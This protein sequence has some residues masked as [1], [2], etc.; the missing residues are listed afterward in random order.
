MQ[1]K[2]IILGATGQLGARIVGLLASAQPRIPI[3]GVSRQ[4]SAALQVEHRSADVHSAP[5]PGLIGPGDVVIDA[6]GPH[7]HDPRAWVSATL[8]ANAHWLDLSDNPEFIARVQEVS[9]AKRFATSAIPGCSTLPALALLLVQLRPAAPDE[10]LNILLSMGSDN[11]PTPS[12]IHNLLAPLG[13]PIAA[14][15]GSPRAFHHSLKRVLLSGDA[16]VYGRYPWPRPAVD[17]PQLWIGFDRAALATALR[18]AAKLGIAQALAS[19][20]EALTPFARWWRPLGTTKGSLRVE[21][22][23][24]AKV[25]AAVE[26]HAERDGLNIPAMPAA[27]AAQRLLGSQRK[28]SQLGELYSPSEAVASLRRAGCVVL[29]QGIDIKT[30][31]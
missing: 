2:V 23:D 13:L 31:P 14:A 9:E 24:A 27:W 15:P 5:P 17:S 6:I 3:L 12:M 28:A 4:P 26:V 16:R 20:A 11:P 30:L 25:V 10:A 29:S 8:A 7:T 21:W 18:A 19:H 22:C 1:P